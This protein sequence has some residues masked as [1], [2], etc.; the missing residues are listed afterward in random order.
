MEF[1]RSNS[2][3]LTKSWTEF[4]FPPFLPGN[5]KQSFRGTSRSFR[6]LPQ[7]CESGPPSGGSSTWWENG[8]VKRSLK[9]ENG[10]SC[11]FLCQRDAFLSLGISKADLLGQGGTQKAKESNM[12]PYSVHPGGRCALWPALWQGAAMFTAVKAKGPSRLPPSLCWEGNGAALGLSETR[13]ADLHW[14]TYHPSLYTGHENEHLLLNC[15]RG[16]FV[17]VVGGDYLL[18]FAIVCL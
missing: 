14:C 9:I 4:S 13:L 15:N 11:P 8:A 6:K 3:S 2:Q 16:L 18:V 1:T 5:M 17:D 12:V 7:P 10:L